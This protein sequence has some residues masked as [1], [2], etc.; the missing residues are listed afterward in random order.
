MKTK[1]MN[2][3][4]FLKRCAASAAS[5]RALS[6]QRLFSGEK[7]GFDAKGL[8]TRILG[9]TGIAIP[10]VV[11]GGGSRFCSVK[12]PERNV[13]ILNYALDHGVFY[14][15][16]GHDYVFDN[17]V[18]EERYGLVLKERRKEVFLATKT[19]KRSYDAGMRDLE[20]SLRRLQTDRLDLLQ[21]HNVLSL[22]DV[23]RICAKDGVL[24]ALLKARDEKITRF[25]GYSGHRSAEAMIAM[26]D[27]FDFD[28][29]L[30]ALNHYSERIGDFEKEAIPAAAGKRMGVLVIKVIRPREKVESISADELVRYAL[31]LPHVNAAVIGTDSLEVLKKNI[32]IVKNFK[33][34]TQEEMQKIRVDLRPFFEGGEIPWMQLDYSDGSPA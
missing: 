29:M 30:I 24:K 22:E 12:D 31:S 34:M 18:S 8:P 19:Q 10:L 3:R 21:V 13:E 2:R 28:T 16:T 25:I 32:E 20:E 9:K 14:W 7:T 11:I 23:D 27:R 1:P 26:A 17:V 5:I 6:F 33:P 4:D 15:D